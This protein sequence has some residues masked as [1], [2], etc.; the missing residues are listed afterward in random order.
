[1][2]KGIC[3]GLIGFG[4]VGAGTAR[5]IQEHAGE[6]ERRLGFPLRLKTICN[7]RIENKDTSWVDRSV[8]LTSDPRL[9]LEDPEIEIVVEAIGGVGAA[10]DVVISAIEHG[11]HVVTANKLLLAGYARELIALAERRGVSLGIEASVAGGIPVLRAVREGLAGERIRAVYG[12][13]NGTANFILSEMERGRSF[14]E[15]LAEAQARGYAEADPRLDIEGEDAR[16]KLAILAMLCFGAS[17]ESSSIPV[18][19]ISRLEAIDFQY[20]AR[21][22]GSPP[23]YTIRLIASARRVDHDRLALGVRPVLVPADSMLGR[24]SGPF[25]AVFILGEKGGETMYYGRGAGGNP[26]GI[27]VV[28]DIIALARDIAARVRRRAPELGFLDFVA[29]PAGLVDQ[30]FPYYL[31]FVVRDRPGII[32][33][34]ASILARHAINIEAV[35]QEPFKDKSRLPFVITLE[36]AL[37]SQIAAALAEMRGLDFLAEEPLALPIEKELGV[38]S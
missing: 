21:L 4:T 19:G 27:A 11:K 9:V 12:I 22:T 30:R 16:D 24:V 37:E 33:A 18:S 15:A 38:R 31:R 36:P 7:R 29:P 23:G 20:A 35:L 26:T 1:M 34:L 17:I 3:V 28:S 8:R 10:R 13:L 32:A 2:G 5:I 6:I 25:N 14:A